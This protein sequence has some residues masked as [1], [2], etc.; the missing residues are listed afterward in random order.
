M[1]RVDKS[2]VVE[3]RFQ[4]KFATLKIHSN[5]QWKVTLSQINGLMAK[6]MKMVSITPEGPTDRLIFLFTIYVCPAAPI[7]RH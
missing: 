3:N 6:G 7:L 5:L 2:D 4:I 1:V